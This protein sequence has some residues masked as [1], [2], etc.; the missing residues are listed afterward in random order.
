MSFELH[1][2]KVSEDIDMP[3]ITT[4]LLINHMNNIDNNIDNINK[5]IY[6]EKRDFTYIIKWLGMLIRSFVKS[7]NIYIK[8]TNDQKN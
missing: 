6:E 8:L 4:Q 7:M 3:I 1:A 5:L 2:S